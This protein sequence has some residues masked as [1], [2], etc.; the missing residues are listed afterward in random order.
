MLNA[1]TTEV[2][3]MPETM[4]LATFVGLLKSVHNG[5]VSVEDW[6]FQV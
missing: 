5:K 2:E 6:L 4:Q 3:L 1:L